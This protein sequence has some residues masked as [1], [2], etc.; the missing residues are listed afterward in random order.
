MQRVV[1]LP[2]NIF[3]V[4][5]L[6]YDD[7][8]IEAQRHVIFWQL[9]HNPLETNFRRSCHSRFQQIF[10]MNRERSKLKFKKYQS[11]GYKVVCILSNTYEYVTDVSI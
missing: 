10:A 9:L 5:I 7:R 2:I 6:R 11:L 4:V 1:A 3:T 8:G